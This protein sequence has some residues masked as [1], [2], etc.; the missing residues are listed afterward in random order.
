MYICKCVVD[1]VQRSLKC[2]FNISWKSVR[3][4]VLVECDS[5]C[6][7]HIRTFVEAGSKIVNLNFITKSIGQKYTKCALAQYVFYEYRQLVVVWV[8]GMRCIQ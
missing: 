3:W 1:V 8:R 5:D 7:R 4:C 2:V 6:K